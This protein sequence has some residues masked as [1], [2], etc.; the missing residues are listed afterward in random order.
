MKIILLRKGFDSAN[1][2]YPSPILPDG[3]LL[4]MPIP[5]SDKEKFWN[6]RYE[7]KSYDELLK[8]IYKNLEIDTCH[9]DP[10]IMKDLKERP[11]EW[12]AAFGQSDAA[13]GHL[14]N[15]NVGKGDIFIFFGSFRQTEYDTNGK[16]IFKKKSPEIH[17]IFG[18][19]QIGNIYESEENINKLPWHPHS[20]GEYIKKTN[21]HKNAIYVA[22][23]KLLDTDYLGYG[24]F[25]Y[26]D[27]LRLT[28][29]GMSKSRWEL[30]SCLKDKRITYHSEKSSK[31]EYFPSASIGQ[32]FVIDAD[33]EI[34]EWVKDLVI[35]CSDI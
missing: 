25:K 15:Q 35:R 9:L 11:S 27:E 26:S 3:T 31:I 17:V 5:S 28:K 2:N 34:L 10:D 6:L 14:R 24:T 33:E 22:S 1:G 30:P 4:S 23:E 18:Y 32:E 12:V 29:E 19:L 16:L 20:N 7:N 21:D 13:L 8:D